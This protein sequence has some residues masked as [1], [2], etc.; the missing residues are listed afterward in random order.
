MGIGWEPYPRGLLL[1]LRRLHRE[2]P[3]LPIYITEN[4]IGTNDDE[5]RQKLLIDHLKMSHQAILEGIP[6]KG[7]F[8][9]SLMDNFEWTHGYTSRF[10]LVH[11]DFSNQTRTLKPS[12][13]LYGMVDS[14]FE[15]LSH[16]DTRSHQFS[17]SKKGELVFKVHCNFQLFYIR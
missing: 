13:K 11:V 17:T 9:W 1:A 16:L 3:N 15:H 6:L 5:W 4:G 7:Y 2:F 14:S 8:H 12:G 10:G